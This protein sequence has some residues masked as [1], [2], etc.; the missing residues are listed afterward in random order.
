MMLKQLKEEKRPRTA[1]GHYL[2]KLLIFV[3]MVFELEA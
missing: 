2:G 1:L 3:G